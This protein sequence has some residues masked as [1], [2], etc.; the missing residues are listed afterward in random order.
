[1]NAGTLVVAAALAGVVVGAVLANRFVAQRHRIL[2]A[3][4]SLDAELARRA[5]L[6]P[7]LVALVQA[8]AEHERAAIER[9]LAAGRGG[10]EDG[11]VA[12]AVAEVVAV[13]ER[14]PALRSSERF[15]EL[16]RALTLTEDRIAVSRRLLNQRIAAYNARVATFPSNVVAR[17]MGLR[18][19]PY[20]RR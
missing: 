18:P 15:V 17:L 2:D 6:V 13:G 9:A 20:G 19:L 11:A 10:A 8:H 1:M 14:T 5:E 12:A 4:A 7:A 16:Q 3:R